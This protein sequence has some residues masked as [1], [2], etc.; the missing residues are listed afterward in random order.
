MSSHEMSGHL[1]C[2]S[3]MVWRML[4]LG[5]ECQLQVPC[6]RWSHCWDMETRLFWGNTW[7]YWYWWPA[8]EPN[9]PDADL[10]FLLT[11]MESCGIMRTY[12]ISASKSH[13]WQQAPRIPELGSWRK[14][15]SWGLLAIQSSQLAN[16]LQWETLENYWAR[17]Q[18]QSLTYTL[19]H[20]LTHTY[21]YTRT[22]IRATKNTDKRSKGSRSHLSHL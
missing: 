6:W 18:H 13:I 21:T 16:S 1:R 22:H 5:L 12:L 4:L 19:T 8:S 20:M 14:E 2:H 10:A 7:T 15:D 17:H 3:P 11:T 9:G